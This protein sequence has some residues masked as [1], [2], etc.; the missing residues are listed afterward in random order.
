MHGGGVS[1]ERIERALLKVARI[2]EFDPAAA[3]VFERLE[4]ELESRRAASD[5]Q[6][7]AQALLDKNKMGTSSLCDHANGPILR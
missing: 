7:R 1:T 4:L 6:R 2:M 3:P 5:V